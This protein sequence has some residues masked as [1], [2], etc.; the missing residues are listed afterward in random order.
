M[1]DRFYRYNESG[2]ECYCATMAAR[3]VYH[4][5]VKTALIKDGWKVTADPLT[6]KFSTRY[7]LQID[8]A[9]EALVAAEKDH[10][11]IAV[12]V[13]SFL[14]PSTVSEFH[15]ALGQ[16]INYR[17]ALRLKEPQRVL[18]L[19]VPLETYEEFFP[20]EVVC[21]SVQENAVKLIV[22][23]PDLEEVTKWIS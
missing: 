8:L 1:N 5:A 21:L 20:E 2:S 15:A 16:F 18:Y 14:A 3:D 17:I 19:A 23:D 10:Q 9:A 13:K 12:E 22:F 4:N 6:L 11:F 7:K